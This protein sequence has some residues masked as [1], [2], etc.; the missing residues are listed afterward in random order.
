V[1]D[2]LT[3]ASVVETLIDLDLVDLDANGPWPGE[4]DDADAY[5]PDWTH[6]H[7]RPDRSS[8]ATDMPTEM[9][10]RHQPYV[11]G[12]NRGPGRG[13]GAHRPVV[14]DGGADFPRLQMDVA[15]AHRD[16]NGEASVLADLL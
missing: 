4:P 1:T 15:A 10:S 2:S 13:V 11:P 9:R 6:V 3:V 7:P 12:D 8:V 14:L 16:L 5:E